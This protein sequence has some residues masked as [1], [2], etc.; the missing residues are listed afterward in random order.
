ML[1]RY[2]KKINQPFKVSI[3]SPITIKFVSFDSLWGLQIFP[4]SMTIF[5]SLQISNKGQC[6][7]FLNNGC[8]RNVLARSKFFMGLV[9]DHQYILQCL[10]T[11]KRMRWFSHCTLKC[12][13]YSCF[14][15]QKK[16]AISVS[17][18]FSTN[19]LL[20]ITNL[21]AKWHDGV[22]PLIMGDCCQYK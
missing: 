12:S 22:N 4:L 19:N 6:P 15:F 3:P 5:N 7:R 11:L 10:V 13:V 17:D 1:H 20:T 14:P 9:F 8:F 18:I 16:I 21:R 2:V